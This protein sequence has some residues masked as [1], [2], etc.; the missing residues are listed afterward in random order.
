[1][2]AGCRLTPARFGPNY[3]TVYDVEGLDVGEAVARSGA[4]MGAA[5]QAGRLLA[6]HSGGVRAALRPAGRYGSEGFRPRP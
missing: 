4:A 2:P 5:H 6:C 1:M 3:L